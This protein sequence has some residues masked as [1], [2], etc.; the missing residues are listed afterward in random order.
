MDTITWKDSYSVGIAAMDEQH[1]KLFVLINS[2]NQAMSE[3]KGRELVG[4]VLNEMVDYT[5]KHF[6]AEEKLMEKYD[7]PG[8]TEQKNEHKAFIQKVDQMQQDAKSKNL[9]ISIEVSQFLRRWITDHIMGMDKNY[10][11]YLN[12]K[13]VK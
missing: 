12:A 6:T 5:S 7:Y 4:Q 3:G 8:L 11:S 2:L 10:G 9:T 13:G 1:K